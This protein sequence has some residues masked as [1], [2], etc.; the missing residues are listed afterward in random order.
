MLL[1]IFILAGCNTDSALTFSEVDIDHIDG[2]IQSFFQ[3]VREENGA[4]LYIDNENTTLFVYLNGSNVLQGEKA[5][6]FTDFDVEGDSSTLNLSYK[7]E[8]TSDYS[9][10]S[11]DYERFY[12]VKVDKVPEVIRLYHNDEEAS[13][14]TISGN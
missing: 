3:E 4:H 2:E 12:R 9:N 14:G 6:T 11:L 10:S 8:K 1:A 13:F 7:S 5:V